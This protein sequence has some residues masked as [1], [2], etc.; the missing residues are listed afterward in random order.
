MLKK[1]T[2]VTVLLTL[3]ALSACNAR[4][5]EEKADMFVNHATRKFDLN[6]N[7]KARLLEIA[8]VTLD[9]R[10]DM[11]KDEDQIK[12]ELINMF[13]SNQLDQERIEQIL[14]EK[15]KLFQHYSRLLIT[16]VAEFHGSLTAEQRKEIAEL[17][18]K[19]V[20]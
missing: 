9:L 16:K 5:P 18:K 4:T 11:K 8:S 10:A 17:L 6:D 19:R 12:Q 7:Q 13:A 14:R 2:F 1:I 15:E 3:L 20:G